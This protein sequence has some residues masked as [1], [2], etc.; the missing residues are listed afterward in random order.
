MHVL[1]IDGFTEHS[2]VAVTVYIVAACMHVKYIA[3]Y[4][5]NCIATLIFHA[6][7]YITCS[8]ASRCLRNFRSSSGSFG[9]PVLGTSVELVQAETEFS[10]LKTDAMMTAS[11][12]S[13]LTF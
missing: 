2:F 13:D 11:R 12:R 6:I 7:T 9:S 3:T 10:S 8:S 5:E 4:L 1:L